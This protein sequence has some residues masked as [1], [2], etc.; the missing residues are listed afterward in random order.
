MKNKTLICT[1]IALGIVVSACTPQSENNQNTVGSGE[2]QAIVGQNIKA[3]FSNNNPMNSMVLL[4]ITRFNERSYCGGIL[5]GKRSVLTAAHC[6]EDYSNTT[7]IFPRKGLETSTKKSVFTRSVN[8]ITVHQ[9]SSAEYIKGFSNTISP[10][11]FSYVDL[12]VVEL[13]SDA[14]SGFP[15]FDINQIATDQDLSTGKLVGFGWDTLR[16]S[17]DFPSGKPV[18]KNL[19]RSQ[20]TSLKLASKRT[21]DRE[22]NGFPKGRETFAQFKYGRTLDSMYLLLESDN[23][24]CQGDSGS[25]LFVQTSDGMFKLI[26]VTSHGPGESETINNADCYNEFAFTNVTHS[27]AWIFSVLK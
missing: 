17:V 19:L 13:E 2:V 21:L 16:K 4:S 6:H 15:I 5:I 18:F 3:D 10:E 24:G 20:N 9:P 25:P 26:G 1:I 7:I 14:P 22:I 27:L 8:A 11:D 23:K 12:A